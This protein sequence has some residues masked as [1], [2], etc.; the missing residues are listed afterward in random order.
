MLHVNG[1]TYRI[2]SEQDL[3]R[4]HQAALTVLS[5]VGVEVGSEQFLT[6]L[7]DVGGRVERDGRVTIPPEVVAEALEKVPNRV[8]LHGRGEVPPLDLGERRVHL[9]TGGAA[10][11]IL[12]LDS[13]E[14]RDPTLA[15]LGDIAWL[16][17][18]LEN[19]HFLL[20]PVVARDVPPEILD[21]NKFYTC[22]ANTNKHVMASAASPESAREVIELAGMVAGGKKELRDKPIISFV[23][24][25]MISPLK[26]DA[27]SAEVLLAV[28]ESGIPVALSCSGHGVDGPG[29]SG[30]PVG[31]GARRG[32]I[33]DRL[34]AGH[35]CG[36]AS[37]LRTGPGGGGYANHELPRR[38]HRVGPA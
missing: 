6:I 11:N 14:V 8:V 7:S 1:G 4:I 36:C 37:P 25:W 26:L 18:N 16:V 3:S 30:R 32:A 22:L 27:K 34:N 21:I 31:T 5:R 38:C 19:I 13:G 20:R 35:P 17:E 2:L 15:D 24:S 23:T 28:I 29:Y 33:R 9:G 12:D 10:V